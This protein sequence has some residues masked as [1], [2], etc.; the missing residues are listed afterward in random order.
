MAC[1]TVSMGTSGVDIQSPEL[2]FP[3]AL[4]S[5]GMGEGTI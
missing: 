4:H 1:Y 3:E 2:Q 5:L